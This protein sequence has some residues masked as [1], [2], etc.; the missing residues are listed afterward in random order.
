MINTPINMSD[1]EQTTKSD[2]WT[3]QKNVTKILVIYLANV[4][5]FLEIWEI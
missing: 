1:Y 3:N 2:V 5:T 4:K